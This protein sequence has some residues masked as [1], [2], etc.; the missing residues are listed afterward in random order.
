A[1]AAVVSLGRWV[2]WMPIVDAVPASLRI[3]RYPTKAFFSIHLVAALLAAYGLDAVA[4]GERR[5]LRVLAGCG[6]AAA[7]LLLLAPAGPLVLPGALASF[8]TRLFPATVPPDAAAAALDHL[9]RDAALGGSIALL[10][11]LLG[12]LVLSERVAGSRAALAAAA[13]VAADLLR[14]GAALNPTIDVRLFRL[15]PETAR[16]VETARPVRLHTCNLFDSPAYWS[17]RAAKPSRHVVFTFLVMRDA[18][19]PHFNVGRVPSALGEDL[20]GLVPA[21][22]TANG[23]TCERFDAMAERLRD[24]AVTHVASLEPL[25]SPQLEPV[26]D[27]TSPAIDPAVVHVYALR[28]PQPRVGLLGTAGSVHIAAERTDGLSLDVTAATDGRVLVRDG[29]AAGWRATVD[30]REA[31]IAE[32]EGHRSLSVSAGTHRVEMRY[33]PPGLAPGLAAFAASAAVVLF[34]AMRPLPPA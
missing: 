28:D 27:L 11:A 21:G 20:T 4:G 7:A 9:L 17:A 2:G 29:F 19:L 18:L 22:R 31:P 33:H 16:L 5:A 24:A 23:L 34:L 32:H 26:R 1:I 30:G 15:A 25:A 13:L 14:T 6:S 3:F 10:V 8:R 12:W